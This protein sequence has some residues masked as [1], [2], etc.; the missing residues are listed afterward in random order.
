MTALLLVGGG[1]HCKSIIDVIESSTHFT[2]RGIVQPRKNEGTS[3]LGYPI[4]GE[5]ADLPELLSS[6]TDALITVGQIKTPAIRKK[7][8]DLMIHLQANMPILVSDQ[9]YVSRHSDLGKGTVVMHGAI[10]N[11]AASINVNTIINSMALIEHD[12]IIGA[13]CHV[14]TGAR[15]NGGVQIG[16]GSFI[17]SGAIIHQGISI[18]TQCII[19]AGSVVS[20]DLPDNTL[21]RLP[22]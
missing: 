13:H 18:G 5:D 21:Y 1:G 22:S 20:K 2:V 4:L 15:I 3:I 11:A 8:Y 10:V 17:G 19:S 16:D 7:L 12:V 6:G 9:S 14:S